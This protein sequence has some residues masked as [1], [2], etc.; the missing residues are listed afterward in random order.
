[1]TRRSAFVT[2]PGKGSPST[3]RVGWAVITLVLWTA[4]T[5][6]GAELLGPGTQSLDAL[7]THGIVWQIVLAGMMLVGMIA[8]RGWNDLGFRAP[9]CGTLKLLWLPTLLVALQFLAAFLIGLP[10]ITMILLILLNTA[11]VGFSEETMFRGVLYRALRGRMRIWP[12][13]LLTSAMFGAIH[14]LN[15]FITGDFESPIVQAIL[16][17]CS[18]LLL[19]AIFLRTGS[20]WVAIVWHALWDAATFLVARVASELDAPD[21]GE[22]ADPGGWE[23]TLVPL[24]LVL[25]NLLYAL[26][27][28]RRVHRAPPAGDRQA[29]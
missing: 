15:G 9:D 24:A 14:V 27:L 4:I 1:M 17:G 16:A 21:G 23:M 26:W 3:N 22:I 5:F 20:L 10:D 28:L 29:G 19:M 25:P 8:W 12:A 18:G 7:V 2:G 6:G 11:F 13:I